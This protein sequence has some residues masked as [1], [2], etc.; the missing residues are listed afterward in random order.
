MVVVTAEATGRDTEV[1]EVNWEVDWT[2]LEVHRS[3][4]STTLD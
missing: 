3:Y 1:E 2:K 4:M